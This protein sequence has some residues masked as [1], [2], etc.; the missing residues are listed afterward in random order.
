MLR[1]QKKAREDGDEESIIVSDSKLLLAGLLGGA[2]GIF[3]FMF[4][5]FIKKRE[6]FRNI[7]ITYIPAT[8]NSCLYPIYLYIRTGDLLY[9]MTVQYEYWW[10]VS[11]NIFTILFDVLKL[12]IRD[13]GFV[14]IVDY[15]VVFGLIFYIFYYIFKH[16]KEKKYYEMFIY[17]IFSIVAICSTIRDNGFAIASF[18]RYLFGCFPI[19]FIFKKSYTTFYLMLLYTFFITILFLMGMYFF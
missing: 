6:K 4:I 9:F 5:D 8:I 17:I 12:M 15:L 10:R 1:F 18:Y 2:T 16:R 7:L 14:H 3:I 11:T 19:Y 13:P